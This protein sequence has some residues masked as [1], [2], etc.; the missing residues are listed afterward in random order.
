MTHRDPLVQST[1][2][3]FCDQVGLVVRAYR[4]TRGWSQRE[5]AEAVGVPKSTVARL[6]RAA[7]GC[8]LDTVI[9]LLGET[10]HTLGVVDAQGS[11][12]T[13]WSATDLE[14]RD[15]AGRRFP[16]HREVRRVVG[17]RPQW[18]WLHEAMGTGECGPEP[19]WTAEGFPVPPGVRF[20][21]KPRPR[22]PGEGLRWPY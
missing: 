11:L 1:S 5:L 15:R 12:V 2:I 17:A 8:S 6:E 16:A 9:G 19:R 20:G 3:P 7:L 10:G 21:K 22:E 13:D 4:R 14:A 18:W